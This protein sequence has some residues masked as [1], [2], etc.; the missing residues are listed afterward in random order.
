MM[1]QTLA[2][3]FSIIEDIG[4]QL[5]IIAAEMECQIDHIKFPPRAVHP[6]SREGIDGIVSTD[7]I[8]S[9]QYSNE[10]EQGVVIL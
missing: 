4:F 8:S 3:I 7:R 9:P 10:A 5:G 2:G 6:I 1:K